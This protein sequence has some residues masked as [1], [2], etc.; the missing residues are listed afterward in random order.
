[1]LLATI[2]VNRIQYFSSILT[3]FL[4]RLPLIASHNFFFRVGKLLHAYH[5]P[6]T[7]IILLIV[8]FLL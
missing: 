8:W 3:F 1:M 5:D 6:C 2:L 7:F 4:W